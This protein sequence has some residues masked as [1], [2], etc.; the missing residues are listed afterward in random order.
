MD[1]ESVTHASLADRT[2]SGTIVIP[3][4]LH[5]PPEPMLWP[6]WSCFPS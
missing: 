1:H 3:Q 4:A 2:T 6:L 5:A